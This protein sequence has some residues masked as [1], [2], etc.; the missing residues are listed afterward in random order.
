[1][2]IL[3]FYIPVHSFVFDSVPV[4][5]KTQYMCDKAVSNDPFMLK[6]CPDRYKIQEMCDKAVEDLLSALK[7]V[8]DWFVTSKIIK[9]LDNTLFANDDIIFINK[10]T[11]NV[12]LFGDEMG[13]LTVDLTNINLDDANFDENDPIIHVRRNIC[14]QCNSCKK[15]ISKDLM[16]VAWHPTRW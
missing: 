8:P 4:P 15:D 13:I 5:Y 16:S 10:D 2:L 14:K 12:S 1:M 7:F 6:Y 11:D 3:L 9:K